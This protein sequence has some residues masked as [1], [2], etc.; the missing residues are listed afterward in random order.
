M[1]P[2]FH[3]ITQMI[4]NK[5]FLQNS[6]ILKKLLTN[7]QVK[8]SDTKRVIANR[9]W[10]DGPT[11]VKKVHVRKLHHHNHLGQEHTDW[12][13]FTYISK[14]ERNN[15]TCK[16]TYQQT[17]A[18]RQAHC[19]QQATIASESYSGPVQRVML[20]HQPVRYCSNAGLQ[21]DSVQMLHSVNVT[22]KMSHD[23]SVSEMSVPKF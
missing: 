19:Y 15:G 16:I 10:K 14:L 18:R 12:K 17:E 23:A 4:R 9:V 20:D 21:C 6:K 11:N 3:W 22:K 7:E 2:K 8:K 5:E 1:P 13:Y